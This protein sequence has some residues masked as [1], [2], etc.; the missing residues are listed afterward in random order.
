MDL[1]LDTFAAVETESPIR[2]GTRARS[3]ENGRR[4]VRWF[5]D[6]VNVVFNIVIMWLDKCVIFG[7]KRWKGRVE[8][9]IRG[10]KRR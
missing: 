8:R 5:R 10:G 4:W 7:V 1:H 2:R 9:K 3:F 6:G